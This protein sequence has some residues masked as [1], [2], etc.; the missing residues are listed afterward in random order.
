MSNLGKNRKS[1]IEKAA[2][3]VKGTLE[4]AEDSFIGSKYTRTTLHKDAW[5]R[6]KR[7]RLAMLGLGIVIA[8][9]L[10]AIFAPLISP[11]DPIER[12][13]EDSALG[14]SRVYL[15]GTDLLGRDIL[16]R[17]IYGSRISLQVG[18]VAVGISV[19]IGLALGAI[20]GYFGN[21][22][23]TVIM[24][25]ADIFFAFPYILGAIA[26]ITVLGP[27]IIN[28][29]IAIGILGWASFARI[30]RG[31]ILSIKNKEYIEA[32]RALGA[33]NYRI[34]TKHIFPNAFAPI[35]VYAT[36]NVGTAIIVEAALSFLGIG[37]Q[38][39]TPAWGKMLAESLDYI[40]ISP[41]MMVF[42]GLAILITVLG[43]VLLG[44]GLR[45]AFDPRLR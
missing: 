21:I 16:S 23:D 25:I 44:D 15:F 34:I 14:P 41:W 8:L 29:F 7:N 24:R 13:K 10:I 33:S 3:G 28:I 6:L 30:F 45:D 1:D 12:M 26:I 42:P 39:P 20:S 18:V 36:M 40:D 35:I 2:R 32:A 11:Y 38:P 37:V 22:P 43:F 9:I 4:P 19:I 5:K 31:S 27:G 17:V